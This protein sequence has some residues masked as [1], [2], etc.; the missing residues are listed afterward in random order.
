MKTVYFY[1]AQE[2]NALRKIFTGE[3]PPT[4]AYRMKEKQENI[5]HAVRLSM[6]QSPP[7]LL[8]SEESDYNMHPKRIEP[9]SEVLP[10]PGPN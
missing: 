3:C 5:H 1:L 2:G 10:R 4:L 8:V 6:S 7:S 9:R